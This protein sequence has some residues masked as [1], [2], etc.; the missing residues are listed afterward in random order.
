MCMYFVFAECVHA[1]VCVV[2]M[3]V[4]CSGVLC[5][6]TCTI[7]GIVCLRVSLMSIHS[8]TYTK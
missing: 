8:C 6:F 7:C 3:C 1:C 5:M 4:Q 2:C